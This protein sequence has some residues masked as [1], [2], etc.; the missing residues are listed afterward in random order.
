MMES[1]PRNFPD[2]KIE[3]GNPPLSWTKSIQLSEQY[4]ITL[5][6]QEFQ[7]WILAFAYHDKPFVGS[8]AI[9]TPE[10]GGPIPFAS[11]IGQGIQFPLAHAL[12][13]VISGRTGKLTL[14][15]INLAEDSPAFVQILHRLIATFL[16]DR[17][18]M[19][20]K[21]PLDDSANASN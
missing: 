13:E 11:P 20:Q 5:H 21:Q 15:S 3:D 6:I 16:K 7:N 17:A 1:D 10:Q 8:L 19:L 2:H 14:S 9:V 18:K 4:V 12:A